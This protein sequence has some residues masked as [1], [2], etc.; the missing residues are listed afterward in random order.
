GILGIVR[1]YWSTGL[2][3]WEGNA[4]GNHADRQSN[5]L[6]MGAIALKTKRATF[7]EDV[8]VGQ[9]ETPGVGC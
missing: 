6:N 1:H 4:L 2:K 8:F 3:R 5:T 9:K 7:F